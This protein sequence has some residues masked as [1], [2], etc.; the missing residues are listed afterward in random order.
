MAAPTSPEQEEER[1]SLPHDDVPEFLRRREDVENSDSKD[2]QPAGDSRDPR[3]DSVRSSREL[4]TAEKEAVKSEQHENTVGEGYKAGAGEHHSTLRTALLKTRKR[5]AALGAGIVAVLIAAAVAVFISLIPLKILHIM[6]NLQSKFYASAENAMDKETDRLFSNYIKGKIKYWKQGNCRGNGWID[7][8]CNPYSARNS[9]VKK[10]YYGWSDGK[11]EDKLKNDY[12]MQFARRDGDT[13]VYLEISQGDSGKLFLDVSENGFLNGPDT[14]DDLMRNNSNWSPAT[15]NQVRQYVRHSFQDETRYKQVM[16]R[17]KVGRLLERKYGIKRCIIGCKARDNYADWKDNKKRAAKMFIA[18]RVIGPKNAMYIYLFDCLFSGKC[19]STDFTEL[20]P[21]SYEADRNGC[22]LGCATNGEPLSKADRD[23]RTTILWKRLISLYDGDVNKLESD[24][25][26]FRN[27][28]VAAG[29]KYTGARARD[30]GSAREAGALQKLIESNTLRN[31]VDAIPIIG[32]INAAAVV[33]GS[34]GTLQVAMPKMV[35]LMNTT[36]ASSFFTMYRTVADETKEGRVDPEILG[37][38]VSGLGPGVLIDSSENS[39][40]GGTAEAEN[41]P[42][43]RT[44]IANDQTDTKFGT[45]ASILSPKTYAAASDYKCAN[46]QPVPAGKLICDEE[47]INPGG[48]FIVSGLNTMTSSPTWQLLERAANT[49]NDARNG[50]VG[51]V[52]EGL[53]ALGSL[54]CKIIPFVDACDGAKAA[55]EKILGAIAGLA[56]KPLQEALQYVMKTLLGFNINQINTQMSGGRS[57]DTLASGADVSANDFAHYGLGGR[58]LSKQEVA[59][60][61]YEQAENQFMDYKNKPFLSRMLDTDSIYSPISK[62]AMAMPADKASAVSSIM[63]TFS[64]PFKTFNSIASSLFN[65]GKVGAAPVLNVIDD[66]FGVTQYGYPIDDPSFKE[67]PDTYWLNNCIGADSKTQQWNED[68]AAAATADSGYTAVNKTTN[69]C[70]LIQAAVGSAGALFTDDVLS[71]EELSDASGSSAGGG[72]GGADACDRATYFPGY[73]EG[74]YSSDT[75][76]MEK[77][78]PPP[79]G[80]GSNYGKGAAPIKYPGVC[81][82]PGS[83]DAYDLSYTKDVGGGTY[84]DSTGQNYDSRGLK[85]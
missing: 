28:I 41:T 46:G 58:V 44:L 38:F 79:S 65:F 22:K 37:S 5:K 54:A 32:Q 8:A 83:D 62:L 51:F 43:Y 45:A 68:G 11:L 82:G 50:V 73:E 76:Y 78:N 66:P 12:G 20:T 72:A 10:L 18:Q 55:A 16:Y 42:L 34:I 57:F 7:A 48:N 39:Q 30:E 2:N 17:M 1:S 13:K 33:V 59:Q 4:K 85:K 3:V 69:R 56:L 64:N 35:Y 60:N 84:Q 75:E 49:W 21:D 23:I 6:N 15:R 27:G 29:D 14:I 9:L 25:A 80:E 52:G 19:K 26:E 81:R 31:A 70:L 71:P 61:Q 77:N 53:G 47:K 36:A 67:D 40:L 63:S 24:Y 74:G